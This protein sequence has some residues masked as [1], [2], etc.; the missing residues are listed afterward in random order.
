MSVDLT[1]S[2]SPFFLNEKLKRFAWSYIFWPI[3]RY[4]PTRLGNRLRIFILRLFG[5]K[6]GTRCLIESGC[7]FWLPWK[8]DLADYVAIGRSVEVYNY[9]LV[10]VGRMTVISQYC[11]LCTGSH[12]YT[13]PHMPLVWSEIKIGSE[14]WVAAGAWIMPGVEIGDGTVIGARSLVTKSMPSWS[15]CVGNPCIPT[16]TRILK[17]LLE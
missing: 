13:H 4:I 10:R 12:D 3:C 1:K 16:K 5:A 9:G 6:I 14:A 15:V 11:Y 2:V 8:L 17:N 7:L